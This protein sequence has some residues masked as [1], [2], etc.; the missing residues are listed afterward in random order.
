MGMSTKKGREMNMQF[1]LTPPP[2]TSSSILTC[3]T[4]PAAPR[5]ASFLHV[6]EES[7]RAVAVALTT[8][9]HNKPTWCRQAGLSFCLLLQWNWLQPRLFHEVD[10][11]LPMISYDKEKPPVT[12]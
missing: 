12:K 9:T 1:W 4:V 6:P 7:V 8:S 3:K 2:H 10:G 5:H 11:D